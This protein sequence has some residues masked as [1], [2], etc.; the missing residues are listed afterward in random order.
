MSALH[1]YYTNGEKNFL[2][3]INDDDR[4]YLK[5]S[6][7]YTR[8]GSKYSDYVDYSLTE[9][10]VLTPRDNDTYNDQVRERFSDVDL[11]ELYNKLMEVSQNGFQL[12]DDSAA[13][14]VRRY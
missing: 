14:V 6:F 2:F 4:L 13:K 3:Y 9:D 8:N 12:P 7:E 1:C 11:A 5:L 10:G